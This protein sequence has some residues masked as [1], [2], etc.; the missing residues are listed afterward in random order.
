MK[1]EQQIE[2]VW[3]NAKV[4]RKEKYMSTKWNKQTIK[5]SNIEDWQYYW[6]K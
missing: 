2:K 6:N 3:E 4:L 5:D 1:L